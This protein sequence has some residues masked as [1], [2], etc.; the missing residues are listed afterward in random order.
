MQSNPT[1]QP[2]ILPAFATAFA[3]AAALLGALWLSSNSHASQRM[4][5][6][7]IPKH[8][9]IH[10]LAVDRRDPGRLLIATHHGLFQ[11]GPDGMAELISPVMDFM[12][13]SPHPEDSEVLYASGHPAEG[14]NLGFIASGDGG[15]T[16]TQ[17]S[18]GANGPVDFHQMA[19]S[20]AD[21][22]TIYGAYRGL[23]IS[24]DG[25]RS[26][27]IVAGLPERLI[28]LAASDVDSERLYA[29]TEAGLLVSANAGLSWSVVLEGLPI[30]VVENAPEG[31]L[32]AF[33]FGRGLVLLDPDTG[34]ITDLASNFGDDFFLQLT[35]DPSDPAR[36]FA[37]TR[38]GAILASA[39][40][41]RSWGPFGAEP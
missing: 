2:R 34:D 13:F 9:H 37:A 26:W 23:Q 27:E 25:G 19:V 17:I 6:A 36:L 32:Y 35:V 14:G 20:P 1:R 15:R 7:E 16:W 21:P 29:A 10:G 33:M 30:T 24:R 11:A 41:G 22:Q 4:S 3:A 40:Q 28:D 12:G 18:P 39:D 38:S 31:H 5:V 8:T